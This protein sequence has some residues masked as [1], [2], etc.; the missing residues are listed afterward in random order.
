MMRKVKEF[1]LS[2][3]W[4]ILLYTAFVTYMSIAQYA[5]YGILGMI[6]SVVLFY[7]MFMVGWY[8]KEHDVKERSKNETSN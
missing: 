2:I 7:V 6:N 8:A 3:N 4:W 5:E 1:V